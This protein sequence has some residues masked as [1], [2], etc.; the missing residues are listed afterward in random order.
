[1]Q[2]TA[3]RT[4]EKRNFVLLSLAG[5]REAL[6][7]RMNESSSATDCILTAV[8]ILNEG[9]ERLFRVFPPDANAF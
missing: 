5:F 6:L 9:V 4:V 2:G 8:M 3:P 7:T 1:M